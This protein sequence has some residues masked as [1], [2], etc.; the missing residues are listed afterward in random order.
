MMA[1]APRVTPAD[2]EANILDEY[3]FTAHQGATKARYDAAAEAGLDPHSDI[4]LPQSLSLLTICTLVLRNGFVV[5]GTSACASP[6]NY[7]KKLGEKIARENAVDQIWP[8]MGYALRSSL[9][10]QA[11]APAKG[12][13]ADRQA[14]GHDAVGTGPAEAALISDLENAAVHAS[15]IDHFSDSPAT[16]DNPFKEEGQ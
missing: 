3:Y 1:T 11:S 6:E 12:G 14:E 16:L 4:P 7:D 2:I 13:E 9:H 5:M 10:Q 15:E 8:L